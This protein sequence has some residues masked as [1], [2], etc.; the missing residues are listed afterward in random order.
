MS[1]SATVIAYNARC[2][3]PLDKLVLIAIADFADDVGRSDVTVEMLEDFCGVERDRIH[4]AI[5]RLIEG[6]LMSAKDPFPGFYIN[7]AQDA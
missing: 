5:L 6:R 2:A 4:N 3:D 7:L 1:L